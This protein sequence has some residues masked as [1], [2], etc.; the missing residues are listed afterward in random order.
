VW[1]HVQE[2]EPLLYRAGVDVMFHGHVHAVRAP[3]LSCEHLSL[4]H[5]LSP[6]PLYNSTSLCHWFSGCARA[7]AC[8]CVCVCVCV[9][10]SVSVSV[11]VCVI[12]CEG[13]CLC[14]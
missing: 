12:V 6:L 10:V 8:V 5:L 13:G 9:S 2:V 4:S 7:R 11:P 1:L 14:L 3:L